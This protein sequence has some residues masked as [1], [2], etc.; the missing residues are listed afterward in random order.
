M[1]PAQAARACALVDAA[2]AVPYHWGTF[3]V[4]SQRNTPRGWMDRP[5]PAFVAA[6]AE[7]APACEARVLRPGETTTWETSRERKA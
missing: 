4:P 2:A 1:D 6:L 7:H 3:Y 5:G